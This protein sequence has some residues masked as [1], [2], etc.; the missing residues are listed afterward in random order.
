[1]QPSSPQDPASDRASTEVLQR[2]FRELHGPSLHG[3]ALL[4][5]LG[6]RRRALALT[7]DALAAAD[8]HA[9]ELRHPERAAAWL[10]AR[11]TAAA[12]R[13]DSSIDAESRLAA[14]EP[15]DVTGSV[16]AGLAALG[17]R[18][19]AAIIASWVERLDHRDVATVVG[20][21]G[22]RLDALLRRARQR[23][24][25]GASAAP[26]RPSGLGGPLTDLVRAAAARAMT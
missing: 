7:S 12:G 9:A 2:A 1:M 6:D 17:T 13:R 3:F 21:S 15:L 26:N 14:L 16:L 25:A 10:R 11:A 8:A 5:T 24:L 22:N 19:R 23:F 18:E 20:R 4:L